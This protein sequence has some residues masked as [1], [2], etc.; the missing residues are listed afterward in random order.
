[1]VILKIRKNISGLE[2]YEPGEERVSRA[3]CPEG[4]NIECET[5]NDCASKISEGTLHQNC[6]K[7]VCWHA[8]VC[9]VKK[10]E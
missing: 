6:A 7:C 2:I 3:M 5:D 1:M 9:D 8:P 4:Q 10:Y